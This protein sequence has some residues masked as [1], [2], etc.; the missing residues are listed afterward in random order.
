MGSLYPAAASAFARALNGDLQRQAQLYVALDGRVVLAGTR[1][2]YRAGRRNSVVG[3]NPI[4]GTSCVRT[5]SGTI[6]NVEFLDPEQDLPP[7]ARLPD[8]P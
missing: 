2:F 6:L 3:C 7:A 4:G 8:A 5:F 1:K